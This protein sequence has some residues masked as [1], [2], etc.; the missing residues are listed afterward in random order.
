MDLNQ[1][2]L[3]VDLDCCWWLKTEE[4]PESSAEEAAP[5][6]SRGPTPKGAQ[7]DTATALATIM[8]RLESWSTL[9]GQMVDRVAAVEV[10]ADKSDKAAE[11]KSVVVAAAWT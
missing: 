10:F 3:L 11:V 8:A 4:L 5:K 6:A 9:G 2:A 7:D 1:E